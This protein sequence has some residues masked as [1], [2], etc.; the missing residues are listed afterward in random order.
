M[1]CHSGHRNRSR[2][3]VETYQTFIIWSLDSV[4]MKKKLASLGVA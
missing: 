4:K 3:Q 1:Y 2:L